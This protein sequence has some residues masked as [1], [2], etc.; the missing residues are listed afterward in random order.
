MIH[1]L[2]SV[3]LIFALTAP[4]SVP[5]AATA[6]AGQGDTL[7]EL[8]AWI[9][10]FRI[11]SSWFDPAFSGQLERLLSDAR[12]SY[13]E[14]GAH[15]REVILALL[16]VRGIVPN[17]SMRELEQGS[18]RPDS[19]TA[20]VRRAGS[21]ALEA[22][23]GG[24][25]GREVLSWLASEV[26]I[27]PRVHPLERRLAAVELMAGRFQADTQLALFTC[28]S[29]SER[30]LRGAAIGSLAGW[31]DENVD[32]FMAGQ[33]VGVVNDPGWISAKALRSHFEKRPL[34]PDSPAGRE[35]SQALN[36]ATLSEDWRLALRA[37][38]TLGA[39][40]DELAVQQ[41]IEGL[42]VWMQ[43][44]ERGQ[45]SRRLEG[46]IVAEL[47]RRSGR[48][49][50]PHPERW[51]RW[52]Q[53]VQAGQLPEASRGPSGRA[54]RASFFG[55]RPETDKVVFVIDRSGSMDADFGRR[56]HTR[57]E[58][59][60]SQMV[61]LLESL[62]PQTRFGVTLFSNGH[63][64]WTTKLRP[65]TSG[66]LGSALNWARRK[67]ASGGT[68]LQPAIR[69]TLELDRRGRPDL[70][71]LEADTIIVLCDGATEEGSSW[72]EPLLRRVGPEACVVFHCAQ[73]GPGG[74]GTLEGLAALT[75]GE[76]TRVQP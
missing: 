17:G 33:V 58:E 7:A 24:E 4:V 61:Q 62:G 15:G 29:A 5:P 59:A 65:A 31:Q 72:V 2:H 51:A 13:A 69:S 34:S 23:V 16:D 18:Y 25:Q 50:G 70:D 19:V 54:T 46:A 28:A 3:G 22:L 9:E 64:R 20:G 71:R 41:L 56:G 38:K 1:L 57:Y 21:A 39:L 40:N 12:R 32:R 47:Q 52:W 35:L 55:L 43:R 37:V 68:N 48:N 66:N 75:G 73:I 60:L 49:I 27:R 14:G 10:R 36:R 53:V 26:L 74:D 11:R 45:G 6:Q 30:A 63:A 44:R 8:R 42:S 76:F 67:G